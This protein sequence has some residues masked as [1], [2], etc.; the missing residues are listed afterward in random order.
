M[1]DP[2]DRKASQD[3]ALQER[4]GREQK[5]RK[6][7]GDVEGLTNHPHSDG[8]IRRLRRG[9]A[10]ALLAALSRTAPIIPAPQT[11]GINPMM[12]VVAPPVRDSKKRKRRVA[13]SDS[14]SSS[15]D[16]SS[17]SESESEESDDSNDD[18]DGSNSDSS[19]EGSDSDS[20]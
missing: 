20:D 18:S 6:T 10:L 16:E 8:Y 19:S 12:K 5:R 11:N 1:D 13:E 2:A 9:R 3:E 15:S 7:E 17:S 4:I 14:D